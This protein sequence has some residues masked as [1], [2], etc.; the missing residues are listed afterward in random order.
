MLSLKTV[1]CLKVVSRQIFRV[2][3]LCVSVLVSGSELDVLA[4]FFFFL[5]CFQ[6]QHQ[7]QDLE[8]SSTDKSV[9]ENGLSTL[10]TLSSEKKNQH[11]WV[12][13]DQPYTA[14]S[15]DA[16]LA[17][18]INAVNHDQFNADEQPH[19]YSHHNY[20]IIHPLMLDCFAVQQPQPPW[21]AFSNGGIN[22]RP[23]CAKMN[24][25]FTEMMLYL[26]CVGA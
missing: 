19:T 12:T 14:M 10:S 16:V 4:N 13:V 9:S 2:L 15:P 6:E 22:K 3:F 5:V 17:K 18:Y 7:D 26:H 1:S 20:C 21:N 25:D 23:H 11:R 24:D 8:T